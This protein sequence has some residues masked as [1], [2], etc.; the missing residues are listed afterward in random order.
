[1]FREQ[2]LNLNHQERIV[3]LTCLPKFYSHYFYELLKPTVP[4]L[5]SIICPVYSRQE[6]YMNYYTNFP[7]NTR[8]QLRNSVKS[9][10]VQSWCLPQDDY[11]MK[12]TFILSMKC[13]PFSL[14]RTCVSQSS[15]KLVPLLAVQ[16][17]GGGGL[18]GGDLET[19]DSAFYSGL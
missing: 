16:L 15:V 5:S 10:G 7:N 4:T 6:W 13:L 11:I 2:Y 3:V 18:L 17:C 19:P 1:M 9:V 14:L 8:L 12:C